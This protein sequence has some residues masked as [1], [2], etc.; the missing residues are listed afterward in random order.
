MLKLTLRNF[1]RFLIFYYIKTIS[2]AKTD[3]SYSYSDF[4]S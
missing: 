4:K 1:N 3:F 2:I